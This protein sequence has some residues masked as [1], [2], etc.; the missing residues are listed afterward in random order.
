MEGKKTLLSPFF[1]EKRMKNKHTRG[2]ERVEMEDGKRFPQV[3]CSNFHLFAFLHH[4]H[5]PESRRECHQKKLTT[6]FFLFNSNFLCGTRN[7][8]DS[9]HHSLTQVISNRHTLNLHFSDF[10]SYIMRRKFVMR[11]S[12]LTFASTRCQWRRGE[13]RRT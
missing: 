12:S 1:C 3:R 11:N 8:H 10:L 2:R 9:H 13:Q 6:R 7:P 5:N 4:Q